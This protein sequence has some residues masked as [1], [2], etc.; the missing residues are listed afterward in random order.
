MKRL[1]LLLLLPVAAFAADYPRDVTLAWNHPTEYTDG[2]L[3]LDG[4]LANTLLQCDRNDGTRVVDELVPVV[5]LPGDRQAQAFVGA[6][7]LPGTYT[8]FGYSITVDGTSSDASNSVVK[9]YTGKPLPPNAM[10]I[11]VN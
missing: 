1:W 9:R 4:D 7:P 6:I 8:C 2:S 11:V 3:I 5:G 10:S